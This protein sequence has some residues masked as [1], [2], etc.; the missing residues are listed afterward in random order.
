MADDYTQFSCIFD[1]GTVENEAK[2]DNIRGDLAA[3][4]DRNEGVNLGFDMEIDHESGPGVLWIHSDAYGDPEHVARFVLRCA[5]AFKLTGLWGFT[6]SISCSKQ[7]IEAFGGGALALNLGRPETLRWIDC[8]NWLI[9]Q[10][11]GKADASD[12]PAE[13]AR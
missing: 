7:R 3:E 6:W 11:S 5:V 1:V 8:G 2:A 12:A 9:E 4:L 13:D 10:T